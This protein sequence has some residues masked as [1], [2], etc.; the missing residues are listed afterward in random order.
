MFT[1]MVRKCA[2]SGTF[3]CQRKLVGNMPQ[4]LQ[5]SNCRALSAAS[6]LTCHSSGRLWDIMVHQDTGDGAHS[7]PLQSTI[8]A[9]SECASSCY[10]WE[11]STSVTQWG[12][13]IDCERSGASV[14]IL[15]CCEASSYTW[16]LMSLSCETPEVPLPPA[17]AISH[18]DSG[19]VAPGQRK[20]RYHSNIW[21]QRR[22]GSKQS[23]GPGCLQSK[24]IWPR[25]AGGQW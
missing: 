22:R 17:P 24:S 11:G 12:S 10:H 13:L 18:P 6:R 5:G 15:P 23:V 3:F 1:N 25:Q 19:S 14:C 21:W 16:T 8:L 2:A 7:E 4:A 20:K 9:E